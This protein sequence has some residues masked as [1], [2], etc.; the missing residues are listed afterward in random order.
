[1]TVAP[2]LYLVKYLDFLDEAYEGSLSAEAPD[3]STKSVCEGIS[4]ARRCR[5]VRSRL[6]SLVLRP[7]LP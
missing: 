3:K 5:A 6:I 1:M 4:I 7:K 2:G